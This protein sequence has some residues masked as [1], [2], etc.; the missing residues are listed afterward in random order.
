VKT[1]WLLFCAA[2]FGASFYPEPIVLGQITLDFHHFWIS[3]SFWSLFSIGVLGLSTFGAIQDLF[4]RKRTYERSL[5]LDSYLRRLSQR[6]VIF[7]STLFITYIPWDYLSSFDNLMV[8]II[9]VFVGFF[10]MLIAI[11]NMA[12]QMEHYRPTPRIIDWNRTSS[13]GKSTSEFPKP[14]QRKKPPVLTPKA[15]QFPTE[16]IP[17]DKRIAKAQS[18]NR[19]TKKAAE[20]INKRATESASTQS[21]VNLN[22]TK[23]VRTPAKGKALPRLAEPKPVIK[24]MP[25]PIKIGGDELIP[26]ETQTVKP[27]TE[28]DKDVPSF[29]TECG[30]KGV[31]YAKFCK[32]C[33]AT[34]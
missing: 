14:T 15:P 33:G 23:P 8:K 26:R 30:F 5:T 2:V 13:R 12:Q 18:K 31:P 20:I 19:V 7:A 28:R 29:C 3:M 17:H 4:K 11:V 21:Q 25:Q 9:F 6:T 1:I 16:H 34:L 22:P 32:N 10:A 24:I 27:I